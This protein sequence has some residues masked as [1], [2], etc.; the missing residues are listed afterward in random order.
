[1]RGAPITIRC[2]CG[3]QRPVRYGDSW[4]CQSC[5]RTWNTADIPADEYWGAMRAVRRYKVAVWGITAAVLAVFLPLALLVALQY[6]VFAILILGA[7]Y[8]FVLPR[9]RGRVLAQSQNRPSWKLHP[10]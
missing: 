2:D 4:T 1:V 10:Q 5:G 3:E 8:F 6:F 7:F 9:W